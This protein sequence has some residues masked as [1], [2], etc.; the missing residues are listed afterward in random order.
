MQTPA[1][2]AHK[3][4]WIPIQPSWIVAGAIILLAA[5]PQKL[6]VQTRT[7]VASPMGLIVVVVLAG[8]IWTMSPTLGIALILLIASIYIR[9]HVEGFMSAPVLIKDRVRKESPKWLGEEIMSEDPHGIQERTEEPNLLLD[10]VGDDAEAHPWFVEDT[11][12][13]TTQA[14]Q[15]RPVGIERDID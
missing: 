14:I 13:E 9:S 15:E 5:M 1:P 7:L 2:V 4:H 3:L 11:L 8:W 12:G 6:S 10:E